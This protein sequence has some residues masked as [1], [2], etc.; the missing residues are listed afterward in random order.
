MYLNY[1]HGGIFYEKIIASINY[2]MKVTQGQYQVH[3]QV[4]VNETSLSE[5]SFSTEL[6]FYMVPSFVSWVAVVVT[7]LRLECHSTGPFLRLDDVI[8]IVAMEQKSINFGPFSTG[9]KPVYF[10]LK[11][12]PLFC[13]LILSS[14]LSL[15]VFKELLHVFRALFGSQQA[16][17][18][19]LFVQR[20]CI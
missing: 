15:F 2:S 9:D 8:A 14:G 19:C 13:G 20:K 12:L 6:L 18:F 3:P 7:V 17:V 4:K 16:R 5:E 11:S 10:L 1:S